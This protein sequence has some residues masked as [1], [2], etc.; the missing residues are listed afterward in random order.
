MDNNGGRPIISQ[1]QNNKDVNENTQPLD[2]TFGDSPNSS[3]NT[4]QPNQ[5]A[6]IPSGQKCSENSAPCCSGA[7]CTMSNNVNFL[8]EGTCD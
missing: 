4:N 2:N 3:P 5:N 6:C 1:P 7:L 8:G